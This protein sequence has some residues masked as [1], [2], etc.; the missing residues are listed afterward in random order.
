MLEILFLS[1][2][3]LSIFYCAMPGAVNTEA[4]RR[5]L[6]GGFRPAFLIEAGSL[7]G[8]SAWAIIAL[9]GLAFLVTNDI[10]RI[11]IG[12]GGAALLIYLAARAFLDAKNGIDLDSGGS[13]AG[14]DFATGALMSLGNPFQVAFWLGIGGSAIAVL[15]PDPAAI[16]FAIFFF[17][18]FTG[19]VIWTFLYSGLVAYGSRYVTPRLFQAIN[20]ICGAIMVY[21]A[22]TLLWATFTF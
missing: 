9:V 11:V 1:A 18:Y 8:D 4:L 7:I 19:G 5:G 20:V 14:K 21:F 15:V 16:D 2:L 17:G 13:K 3:V 22:V 10:A 12:I 6:K